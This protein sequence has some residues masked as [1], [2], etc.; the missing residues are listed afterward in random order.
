MNFFIFY[1]RWKPNKAM[2]LGQAFNRK[3]IKI[4][5]NDNEIEHRKKYTF[6]EQLLR[7][8]KSIV[9]FNY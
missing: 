1:F 2:Y 3:F 8:L 9:F 4:K 5:M 6:I 7:K